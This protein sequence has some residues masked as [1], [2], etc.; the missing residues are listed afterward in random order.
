ME[1]TLIYVS[2]EDA[3]VIILVI[4]IFINTSLHIQKIENNV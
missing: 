3:Q 1:I 4:I 2:G